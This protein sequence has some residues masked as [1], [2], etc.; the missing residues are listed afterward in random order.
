M[1]IWK[2]QHKTCTDLLGNPPFQ[3]ADII[4]H[5]SKLSACLVTVCAGVSHSGRSNTIS[6]Q[7]TIF[8]HSIASCNQVNRQ[9][10]F[11]I[12]RL[13]VAGGLYPE[14]LH[15]FCVVLSKSLS[16]FR[17][18]AVNFVYKF[19][20]AFNWTALSFFFFF[21]SEGHG[22]ILE[23]SSLVFVVVFVSCFQHITNC[24]FQ[25]KGNPGSWPLHECDQHSDAAA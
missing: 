9:F 17:T 13:A 5:K 14:N 4:V 12:V 16:Y 11:I 2:G 22:I 23:C 21:F 25:D 3:A 20:F 18:V 7:I 19:C 1:L 24:G 15:M 10:L 8:S 6:N